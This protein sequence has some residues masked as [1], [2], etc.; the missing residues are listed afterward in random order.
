MSTS[1]QTDSDFRITY[2]TPLTTKK[3][4]IFLSD[5][6]IHAVDVSLVRLIP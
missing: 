1:L 4:W 5:V 3:F 2:V 6:D